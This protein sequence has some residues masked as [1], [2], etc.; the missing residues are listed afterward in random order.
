VARPVAQ[1]LAGLVAAARVADFVGEVARD[2]GFEGFL[3]C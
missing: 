1:G 3:G 2:A